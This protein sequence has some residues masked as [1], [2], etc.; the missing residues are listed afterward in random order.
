MQGRSV[1]ATSE[2]EIGHQSPSRTKVESSK[3]SLVQL[4]SSMRWLL[5]L[6]K[7]NGS[8]RV[9]SYFAYGRI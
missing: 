4:L 1:D 5:P 8:K 9:G 2:K 3:F 6:S 7:S